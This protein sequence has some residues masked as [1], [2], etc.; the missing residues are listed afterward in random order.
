ML[1]SL[2]WTA[3]GMP[4]SMWFKLRA[5]KLVPEPIDIGTPTRRPL[6]RISDLEA[7]VNSRR[8]DQHPRKAPR[9][10]PGKVACG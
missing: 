3:V 10:T 8:P 2:P 9:R 5:A 4:R 7:W 1:T 6:W